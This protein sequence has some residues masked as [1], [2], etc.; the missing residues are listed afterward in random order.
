MVWVY[1]VPVRLENTR[2][3][4]LGLDDKFSGEV[5]LSGASKR[6]SLAAKKPGNQS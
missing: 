1:T 4:R 3:L 5:T 6:H 2:A